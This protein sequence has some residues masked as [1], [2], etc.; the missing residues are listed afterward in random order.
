MGTRLSSMVSSVA[1]LCLVAASAE[2]KLASPRAQESRM[3]K[4]AVAAS[5]AWR[6]TIPGDFF[7]NDSVKA[8]VASTRKQVSELE[9]S[10]LDDMNISSDVAAMVVYSRRHDSFDLRAIDAFDAAAGTLVRDDRARYYSAK[11][12]VRSDLIRTSTVRDSILSWLDRVVRD[13]CSAALNGYDYKKVI[14]AIK[15]QLENAGFKD[16]ML[17]DYTCRL[18]QAHVAY[19]VARVKELHSAGK[20]KDAYSLAVETMRDLAP[21]VSLKAD[22]CKLTDGAE[23]AK[24]YDVAFLA[25][26]CRNLGT[27]ASLFLMETCDRY[28]DNKAFVALELP[29]VNSATKPALDMF[30]RAAEDDSLKGDRPIAEAELAAWRKAGRVKEYRKLYPDRYKMAALVSKTKR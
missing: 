16:L 25:P 10:I 1:C 26:V 9:R 27:S 29:K 20:D 30:H 17:D 6:A 18:T 23:L 22:G 14:G 11:A 28:W 24:A 2:A 4:S 7:K 3:I 8:E 12:K 19:V 5:D 15:W 13:Y 21:T